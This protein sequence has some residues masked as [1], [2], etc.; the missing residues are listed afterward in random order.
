M[1][2]SNYLFSYLTDPTVVFRPL[3]S[4]SWPCPNPQPLPYSGFHSNEA[5][6]RQPRTLLVREP[7]YEYENRFIC[8]LKGCIIFPFVAS[9]LIA[10]SSL[11]SV[12]PKVPL[13]PPEVL[14]QTSQTACPTFFR[15]LIQHLLQDMTGYANRALLRNRSEDEGSTYIVTI[16]KPDFRSLPLEEMIEKLPDLNLQSLAASENLQQVFLTSLERGY[17]EQNP[18][19]NSEFANSEL[20]N[21]EPANFQQQQFHWLFFEMDVHGWQLVRMISQTAPY[22]FRYDSLTLPRDSTDEPLADAIRVQL[23]DC[24]RQALR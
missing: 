9:L 2:R 10:R 21:S 7:L 24:Q 16:G 23:R 20:A 3:K 14:A 17:A 15:P 4:I 13:P 12:V 22:P 11:A 6:A 19:Q 1:N 5:Q 8:L 18:N